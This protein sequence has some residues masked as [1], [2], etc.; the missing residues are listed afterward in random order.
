VI[1]E[2]KAPDGVNREDIDA[3]GDGSVPSVDAISFSKGIATCEVK[4]LILLFDSYQGMCWWCLIFNQMRD[5]LKLA[6]PVK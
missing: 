5:S 4:I 3:S 1:R 2:F 6:L